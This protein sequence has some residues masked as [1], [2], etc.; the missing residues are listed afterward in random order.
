MISGVKV[1]FVFTDKRILNDIIISQ[2]AGR[3]KVSIH[4]PDT[5]VASARIG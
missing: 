4:Y 5:K 3:E 1:G 2:I